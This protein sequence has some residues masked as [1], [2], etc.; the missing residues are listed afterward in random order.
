[1]VMPRHEDKSGFQYGKGF[2]PKFLQLNDLQFC[3]V[4]SNRLS[5]DS[6]PY[7][8][9]WGSLLELV[10]KCKFHIVLSR[11]YTGMISLKQRLKRKSFVA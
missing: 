10:C 3:S 11:E 5:S 7:M 8:G 4:S 1:M 2:F 6:K 9:F